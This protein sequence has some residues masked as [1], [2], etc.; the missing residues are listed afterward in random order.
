[1]RL[2][3]VAAIQNLT[4]LPVGTIARRERGGLPEPET[5]RYMNNRLVALSIVM[6]GA[7]AFVSSAQAQRRGTVSRGGGQTG[8]VRIRRG[9]RFLAGSAY[10]PYFYSDYAPGIIEAPP[11]QIIVQTAQP[12]SPVAA[13]KPLDSLVLELQ[14]DHWVRITNYG[15][16]QAGGRSNQP[17][18]DRGSDLPAAAPRQ[19]QTNEPPIALPGA[20]L[21]YR[22]G[23]NEE[24]SKYTII[25]TAIYTNADYWSSGSWTRK[26]PITALDIPATLKL[27]QERG[28]KFSLPSGPNEV[29]VRP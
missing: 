8:F 16:S 20:V 25:G 6:L 28:S 9:E 11:S 4:L 22:D 13:T 17:D 24:I 2:T 1:M 15:E 10:A 23:Y 7:T 29:I 12:A 18:S 14:G 26:I 5:D 3:T 27:N 19:S 21:V